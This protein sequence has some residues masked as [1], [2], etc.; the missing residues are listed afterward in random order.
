ML[1]SPGTRRLRAR[2]ADE[3]GLT[4]V[5]LVAVAGVVAGALVAALSGF[6]SLDA[7][8]DAE[9]AQRAAEDQAVRALVGLES[10][11][12]ATARGS[13]RAPTG[14]ERLGPDE[15]VFRAA[16]PAP[17]GAMMRVRYCLARPTGQLWR[18]AQV[19]TSGGAP[20]P[21]A[22]A[23]C[24]AVSRPG[25]YGMA[26]EVAGAMANAAALPLFRREGA[27]RLVVSV[28]VDDGT[29]GGPQSRLERRIALPRAAR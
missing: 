4:V 12:R 23:A 19:W 7:R 26:E 9:G 1:S 21:R 3:R 16:A 11:L 13:A 8:N 2:L 15:L 17:A 20:P 18:Q 28:K 27:G 22:A 10:E 14:I 24:P 5:E 6:T 25:E 29:P